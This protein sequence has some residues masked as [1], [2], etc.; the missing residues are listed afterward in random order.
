MQKK[1]TIN[2]I[3][4]RRK[5]L[6][7]V[8]IYFNSFHVYSQKIDDAYFINQS[9]IYYSTWY[10]NQV[11]NKP[12]DIYDKDKSKGY[13][14]L[15]N[16]E[17]ILSTEILIGLFKDVKIYSV[18]MGLMRDSPVKYVIFSEISGRPFIIKNELDFNV[19]MKNSTTNF[20]ALD[21]SILYSVFT[22]SFNSGTHLVFSFSHKLRNNSS[23]ILFNKELDEV[24]YNDS[25][26]MLPDN[27]YQFENKNKEIIINK[28]SYN[29]NSIE[30]MF[31]YYTEEG[32][33][34]S[35]KIKKYKEQALQGMPYYKYKK[36]H[37]IHSDKQLETE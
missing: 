37:S 16:D 21:K 2:K 9:K 19:L 5:T 20:S 33:L 24:F 15:I 31:F 32:I 17:F 7:I 14:N 34:K 23:K 36:N 4:M 26:V 35:V 22:D 29:G 1:N 13:N 27:F 6:L 11:L 28:Y 12:N 30:R 18:K 8:I 25:I 10:N 3:K